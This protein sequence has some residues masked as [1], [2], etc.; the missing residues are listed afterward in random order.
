MLR[1]YVGDSA[2]F[3]AL[4]L[5]LTTNKF[6]SAE[7]QQLR[8]AFEEV[9]GKDLNWYWN[10]WYYGSGHPKF[11]I[12]Y[13]Y[14]DSTKNTV[15]IVKQTQEGNKIFKLPVAIDVYN[16]TGKT[17]HNVWVQNKVD[18]FLFASSAKPDL[19]NFDGD[20]ILLCTKIENKTPDEYIYQYKYAGKYLDRKEAID[21]LAKNQ[22]DPKVVD[23]LK[24]AL[25]DKYDG[26][27]SYTL[28][29]LEM[30]KSNL[31]KEVE[32]ILLDLAKNDPKRLVRAS[33]IA[34]L[35]QYKRNEYAPLFKNA[36]NDSSYTVSGNA[37]EAL[38]L[39]DSATAI[40]EAKRLA[41]QPSK[42]KL[43]SQITAVLVKSGDESAAN[44]ILDNFDKMP[45]SQAKFEMLQPISE[46]LAN[47]K[48]MDIL[49]RGVDA[50]AAFRDIIPIAFKNQ[51][52]PFINGVLLKGLATK[53]KQAG[54]QDQFEYILSKLPEAD[55]KGF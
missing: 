35:G 7:A 40:A 52:D 12:T 6:K 24:T 49:K 8:L 5:Y 33:A 41:A 44:I 32:P 18:T 47:A 2:F 16:A 45:L 34:K 25:K 48:K 20:K 29:K 1:N 53:K 42:G 39:I 21:A 27:R 50:I 55:K 28:G 13:S 46:F 26:L 14:N 30:R 22:D 51:T 17:R 15:V 36:V 11:D 23:F 54:L 31:K 4:N 9:T 37:L 38:S 19:V 3:K 43:S 10:Q